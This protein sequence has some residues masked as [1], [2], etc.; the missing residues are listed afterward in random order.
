MGGFVVNIGRSWLL[1]RVSRDDKHTVAST[2]M[3]L[4]G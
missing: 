3:T 4:W 1:S 2:F